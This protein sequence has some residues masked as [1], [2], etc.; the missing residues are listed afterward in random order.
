MN[1]NSVHCLI[2]TVPVSFFMKRRAADK[3]WDR[4]HIACRLI[5]LGQDL[6][7]VR[8]RQAGN[9]DPAQAAL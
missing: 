5:E 2:E 7:L 1:M 3:P 9:R 8:A 4:A 6:R